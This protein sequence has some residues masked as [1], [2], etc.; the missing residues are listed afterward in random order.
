MSNKEPESDS[1]T[2]TETETS[3]C[4]L[5]FI[6]SKK[7]VRVV[8]ISWLY[9]T[10][11]VFFL[12]FFFKFF[13]VQSILFTIFIQSWYMM[14]IENTSDWG[15]Q[16]ISICLSDSNRQPKTYIYT[17]LLCVHD[18]FFPPVYT[19]IQ[20]TYTWIYAGWSYGIQ[21]VCVGMFFS[22]QK[23]QNCAFIY[24]CGACMYLVFFLG[25]RGVARGI[26]CIRTN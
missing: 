2:E 24:W 4:I 10:S 15:N 19:C 21:A 20:Y 22:C 5:I 14:D 3:T 12:S 16:I 9:V 6:S 1:A 8:S 26:A 18:Y 11:I 23:N 17:A 13:Y 25:G 7:K